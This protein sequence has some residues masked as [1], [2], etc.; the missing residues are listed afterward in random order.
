MKKPLHEKFI[1]GCSRA[2][3]LQRRATLPEK[4]MIEA[5]IAEGYWFKFQAFFYADGVLFLPDFRLA[6]KQKKLILEID[7]P[8][9]NQQQEYDKRR[10]AWLETNRNCIVVR[11]SNDDVLNDARKVIQLLSAYEPKKRGDH[12]CP[13]SDTDK[14]KLFA[15]DNLAEDCDP[16]TQFKQF[17]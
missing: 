12:G 7:G 10:T 14:A 16:A 4:I 11:V 9:H 5:L 1:L 8:S 3:Q 17:A 6:T 13:L 2:S 15:I